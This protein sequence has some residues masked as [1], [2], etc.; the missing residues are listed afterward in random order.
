[1]DGSKFATNIGS[2]VRTLLYSR[3]IG[4]SYWLSKSCRHSWRLTKQ[5]SGHLQ[6][7]STRSQ[8]ITHLYAPCFE[9][10]LWTEVRPSR[11]VV[12]FSSLHHWHPRISNVEFQAK[13]LFAN[14]PWFQR[15]KP[16]QFQTTLEGSLVSN[17]FK[18]IEHQERKALSIR[19]D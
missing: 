13:R 18:C 11:K 1:M 17:R 10:L 14:L 5:S 4:N 19:L 3:P 7:Q 6:L 15:N 2:L 12:P 9:W 16:R 8:S